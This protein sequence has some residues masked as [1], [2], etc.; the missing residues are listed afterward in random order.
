[1][2]KRLSARRICSKCGEVFN[3]ITNPPKEF[4]KCDKCGG[5]LITRKDDSAEAV[6]NRFKAY[7]EATGE[8]VDYLRK[9]GRFYEIDADRPI[10][11][12]FEDIKDKINKFLGK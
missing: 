7:R 9:E 2:V 3:L 11:D 12:I 6:R 5:E 1:M 8:L 10:E 4:G